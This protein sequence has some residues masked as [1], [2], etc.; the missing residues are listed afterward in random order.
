MQ[1]AQQSLG[2]FYQCYRRPASFLRC[3]KSFLK[4]YPHAT[5]VVDNDGGDNFSQ[6]CVRL[7]PNVH[8]TQHSR[9]PGQ[10]E[11]ASLVFSGPERLL[12]F[13]ERLWRSF[14][15]ITED[16]VLLLEDDVRVL[17]RHES[18]FQGAISGC[19][20][21]ERLP[22]PMNAALRARM[23]IS[24]VPPGYGACGGCVLNRKFFQAIPYDLARQTLLSVKCNEW[25][26]DQ[27]LSFICLVHGGTILP[28][29]EFAETWYSDLKKRMPRVAFLH[30]FKDDYNA[31]PTEEEHRLLGY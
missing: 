29:E 20:A 5:V 8:Y 26:S 10:Q 31:P 11:T 6:A 13:L 4:Q 15:V 7:G 16:F 17:K 24:S 30:K 27:A 14:D 28:N 3:I 21:R 19:N 1:T 22:E 18:L 25:A 12:Q 9:T 23:R 2:A